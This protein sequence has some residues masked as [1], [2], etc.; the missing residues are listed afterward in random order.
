M[1]SF[2]LR[3]LGYDWL[4]QL[5]FFPPQH[6]QVL[7]PPR[8]Q[9][10]MTEEWMVQGCSGNLP[11]SHVTYTIILFH[12]SKKLRSQS[13]QLSGSRD[14]LLELFFQIQLKRHHLQQGL[15]S[16]LFKLYRLESQ[17]QLT[18][19]SCAVT[20]KIAFLLSSYWLMRLWQLLQQTSEC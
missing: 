6:T 11:K 13:Y 3:Y 1:A 5:E 15:L 16:W 17:W 10:A 14:S 20:L 18:R 2:H 9:Q 19:Q 7:F 8:F 4:Y 12:Q